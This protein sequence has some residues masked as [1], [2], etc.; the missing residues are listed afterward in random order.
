MPFIETVA[1]SEAEGD[2]RNLYLQQSEPTGYLPNYA[3]VYCHNPALMDAWSDMLK[4]L[5]SGLD[6]RTAQL[7][8]LAVAQAVG[9]SYCS[10]A[11][12]K[13]LMDSGTSG[14]QLIGILNGDD[15]EPS[16]LTETEAAL[17][18]LAVKAALDSANVTEEDYRPLRELGVEES[19]I[20]NV[21]ATATARCF[22][23]RL[24][25]ALGVE[26]DANFLEMDEALRSRLVV[27]RPIDTGAAVT[28]E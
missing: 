21:V 3:K 2:I 16:L 22:F 28:V 5:R 1:P 25:D 11:F 20:F 17:I 4:A 15:A 8:N 6:K 27:G 10:L 18:K 19:R 9:S 7:V 14:A 23:A 26:A 24:G 12:A 13:K